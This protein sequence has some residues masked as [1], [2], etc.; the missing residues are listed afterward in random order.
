MSF[1]LTNMEGKHV[2]LE[3]LSIKHKQGL[4]AAIN[5]GEL[6]KLF[7]TLVPKL[8]DID[9]FFVQAEADAKAGTSLVFASID[10]KTNE[11]AGST[12]FM[13]AVWP[14]K[15]IEIGYTFLG[16]T[17]QKTAINTEAK[18]LMLEHAFEQ[19]DVNRVELL[20]DYLNQNSRRAILRLGANEE[21]VLRDHMVMPDDRVRDS[22]IYSITKNNW[23]GIK[24]H[25]AYKLI[26]YQQ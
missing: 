8:I 15:R 11:V 18:F 4:C 21:G 25:L 13:K 20:T 26:N 2:R 22:V 1:E 16:E 10:K 19:L 17:W 7:F 23:P 3:P 6:W 9:A 5:D 12:R 14:H 24:Q